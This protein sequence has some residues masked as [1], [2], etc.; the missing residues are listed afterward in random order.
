MYTCMALSYNTVD[1]VFV[2]LTG[3]HHTS[4]TV[5]VGT[6]LPLLRHCSID[7]DSKYR[8]YMVDLQRSVCLILNSQLLERYGFVIL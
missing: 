2:F 3:T 4:A 7:M 1:I 8:I 6:G 5:L